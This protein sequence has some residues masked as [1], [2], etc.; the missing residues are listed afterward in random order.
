MSH[1]PP[2]SGG[3]PGKAPGGPAKHTP[4]PTEWR[5]ELPEG[6]AMSDADFGGC[7]S[8]EAGYARGPVLGQG[9]YGEVRIR[10]DS[11]TGPASCLMLCHS[12]AH[13]TAPPAVEPLGLYLPGKPSPA[14]AL[15]ASSSP[16][17]PCPTLSCTS[18]AGR[19]TWL[20]ICAPRRR[21]LPRRSRW[22]M[23]RRVSPSQ[24]S[25]R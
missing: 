12:I 20:M 4:I 1:P 24:P 7:R 21:L 9:T 18:P 23:R 17:P 14:V 13:F 25:E 22:T 8:I 3:K 6:G 11:S 10:Q 15:Q 16:T 19:S 2:R 5:I